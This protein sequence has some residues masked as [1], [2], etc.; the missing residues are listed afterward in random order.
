MA[1]GYAQVSIA[2]TELK[3]GDSWCKCLVLDGANLLSTTVASATFAA[4]GTPYIQTLSPSKGVGFGIK[5]EFIPP[6]VLNAVVAAV[7]AAIAG[8]DSVAVIAEDDIHDIEVEAYP[9]FSQQWLSDEPQRTNPDV[10][11]NV[12]FR[13][14]TAE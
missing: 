13:F 3:D 4:D 1:L 12:T 8:G 10:V 6:D 2:G 5:A 11:K 9:D 7:M 14:I